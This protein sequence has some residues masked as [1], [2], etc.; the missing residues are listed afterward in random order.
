MSTTEP[1]TPR[2]GGMMATYGLALL[3]LA[4]VFNYAD[5]ALLGIVADSVMTD[6]SLTD[7]QYSLIS[8]LAFSIFNLVAGIAIARWVDRGDRK[9]ILV[10][11][12]LMWTAATAATGLVHDFNTLAL[13]RVLV[14]VGEAT[15]FPVAMS[16]LADYFP[17]PKLQRS[18]GIFQSS[19]GVGIVAGS[20]LAG[21]L[22]AALGG[23]R[24]MFIAMGL[25]GVVL[26][27]LIAIS[28]PST[29]RPV[30]VRKEG[31]APP[32]K[33]DGLMLSLKKIASVPGLILL[34]LGYAFSHIILATL[35]TWAPTFLQRSYGVSEHVVGA[36]VGPPAVAGGVIGAILSGIIATR[37][38][39][40]TG[41]RFAGLTVPILAL[42]LTIPA[43]ALFLF[44]P[45]IPLLVAG[46]LIM[47]LMI[48]S[49]HGP[50]IALA[51]SLVPPSQRGL[52][53]TLVLTVMALIAGTIV[54]LGVGALSDGLAPSYG[55]D[56]L[57]YALLP[58]ILA[59]L[60]GSVLI[61]L[62][63]RRI[64]GSPPKTREADTL[65][66]ATPVG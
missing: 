35:P 4:N 10:L 9:L 15:V 12:V 32:L 34:T 11:G 50:C 20:I 5:R 63:R 40:K 7:T 62:A 46:I 17:G 48:A 24:M 44:A 64:K 47:N 49:T 28:M 8:G 1:D 13:T 66:A 51:V 33:I 19:T 18:V 21:V 39:E 58:L 57:R 30:A 3:F 59:P 60:I 45:S 55:D 31:D 56:S 36:L 65:E 42:P 25:A 61:W 22:T 16:L 2:F 52:T 37:L 29:K 23:W 26:V 6:L 41:D 43:F 38:V 54:P 53:S 27:I 14:G